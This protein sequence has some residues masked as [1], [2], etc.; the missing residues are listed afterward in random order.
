MDLL[1]GE[2]LTA[3]GRYRQNDPAWSAAFSAALD[4]CFEYR[5]VTPAAQLGAAVLPLL[6]GCDW[7]RNEAFRKKLLTAARAQAVLYPD[8]LKVP[9]ALCEPLTATETQVLRLLCHNRSNQEIGEILGIRLTTVKTHVSHILQK[10]G[11]NGRNEA[12]TAAE[13]LHLL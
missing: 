8:F 5:F 6:T 7:K 9:A 3:L 4:I 13:Q 12:K 11:V 2:L 10:L 1:Y